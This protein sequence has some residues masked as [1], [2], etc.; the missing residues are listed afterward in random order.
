[1][2]KMT[3]RPQPRSGA[4]NPGAGASR[5]RVTQETINE[6]AQLRRQGLTFHQIGQRVACSERTAR[7]YVGQVLP[8]LHLPEAKP[9][10]RAEDPRRIRARLARGFS[11]DLYGLDIYP[12]PRDSVAFLAE[13]TRLI[14]G[15]LARVPALT[16]ELMTRER[17]LQMRF[18]VAT[19][20]PLF[21][22][23]KT[24][25]QIENTCGSEVDPVTFWRPSR[26]LIAAP[27]PDGRE[28]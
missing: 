20:G 2:S 14:E 15:G 8:D 6:M 7:R 1:M 5:R 24:F 25:A 17:A 4:T 11:D 9:E 18:L 26:E 19:V 16:L 13:A 3:R 12:R 10:P 28:F 22:E 27:S 23:F 21:Q